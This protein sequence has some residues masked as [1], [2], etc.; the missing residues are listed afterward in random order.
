MA[1]GDLLNPLEDLVSSLSDENESSS[2]NES[3]SSS[4]RAT[5]SSSPYDKDILGTFRCPR[6]CNL[7][8]PNY[9]AIINCP[10]SHLEDENFT[11][12]KKLP[13][14]ACLKNLLGEC[15]NPVAQENLV[16][17]CKDGFHLSTEELVD[18]DH[19]SEKM[20]YSIR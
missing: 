8:E 5:S 1:E 2:D 20:A 10:F 4:P 14:F 16:Q 3:S 6:D 7:Y 17:T 15:L 13:S 19:Y 12:K 11:N 9:A 18:L